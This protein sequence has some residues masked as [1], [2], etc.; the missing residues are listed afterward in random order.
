MRSLT[1]YLFVPTPL[2]DSMSTCKNT[3]YPLHE[4]LYP[5]YVIMLLCII[6]L[7][8]G[9]N[10]LSLPQRGDHKTRKDTN[11]AK[12]NKDQTQKTHKQWEQK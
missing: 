6:G 12:Q 5:I 7:F 9:I 1:F 4:V 8:T 3:L 10:Q 2:I 11:T